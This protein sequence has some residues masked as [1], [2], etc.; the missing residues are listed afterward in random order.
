MFFTGR[1]PLI[2][3]VVL[4]AGEMVVLIAGSL[5]QQKSTKMAP[6]RQFASKLLFHAALSSDMDKTP[7]TEPFHVWLMNYLADATSTYQH[8]ITLINRFL[9]DHISLLLFPLYFCIKEAK[10]LSLLTRRILISPAAAGRRSTA[11]APWCTFP[12]WVACLAKEMWS[13]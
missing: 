7:R 10:R 6:T 11:D 12:A 4:C 8:L 5:V 9:I 13:T 2:D 3:Q 1:L